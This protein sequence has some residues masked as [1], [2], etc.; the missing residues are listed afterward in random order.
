MLPILI[1]FAICQSK[2]VQFNRN[3]LCQCS[4]FVYEND[5]NF[6]DY[7]AWTDFKCIDNKCQGLQQRVCLDTSENNNYLFCA[8]N[9]NQ[10]SEFRGC[11][12]YKY[13][14]KLLC[15]QVNAQCTYYDGDDQCSIKQ[16]QKEEKQSCPIIAAEGICFVYDGQCQKIEKCE[17]IGKADLVQCLTLAGYCLYQ[18]GQCKTLTSCSQFIQPEDCSYYNSNLKNFR[19]TINLCYW[20]YK[21]GQCEQITDGILS[22]SLTPETCLTDSFHTYHW[23]TNNNQKGECISCAYGYLLGIIL[24]II[25]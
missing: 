10:C 17:D 11:E 22:L 13:K 6:N 16:C 25:V 4:Q 23:S 14:D 15:Q 21:N 18:A 8:W 12:Y 2:L 1:L 3:N 9:N 5:C 7:C 24:Y 20:N 19:H